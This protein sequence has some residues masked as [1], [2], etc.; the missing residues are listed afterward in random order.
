[1]QRRIAFSPEFQ[2]LRKDNPNAIGDFIRI[3]K[4]GMENGTIGGVTAKKL[5]EGG[6]FNISA[7][8]VTVG[9]KHFFVKQCRTDYDAIMSKE[10]GFTQFQVM[11]ALPS[12]IKLWNF[13]HI[14]MGKCYL[15]LTNG[16]T[17]FL[18][19]DFY[20]LPTLENAE[21]TPIIAMLK[22]EVWRFNKRLHN[23][24]GMFVDYPWHVFIDTSVS[25]AII[26]DPTY[27]LPF[28]PQP[29]TKT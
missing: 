8:K 1:M 2:Q 27:N 29:Q 4:S 13:K 20:S 16:S 22:D 24:Y 26:I 15:G 28:P 19:M 3:Y 23:A 7:W 25:R 14:E 21:N 6:S 12:V 11:E 9:G 17:S 10:D 18:V 5:H